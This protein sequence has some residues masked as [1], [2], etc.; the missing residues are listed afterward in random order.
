MSFTLASRTLDGL[1]RFLKRYSK[2]VPVNRLEVV[3][4]VKNRRHFSIMR[5]KYM[6]EIPSAHAGGLTA[7]QS[8]SILQ[9]KTTPIM[10]KSCII[11]MIAQTGKET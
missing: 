3:D 2:D 6:Q 11:T 7:R 5:S 1:C 8:I 10:Q 4:D 9:P